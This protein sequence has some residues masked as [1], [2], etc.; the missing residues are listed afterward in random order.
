MKSNRDQV[1]QIKT[2]KNYLHCLNL[3]F[4]WVK[5]SNQ[6]N[7]FKAWS[8]MK[9]TTII[10]GGGLEIKIQEKYEIKECSR[11]PRTTYK[12][13]IYCGTIPSKSK[14]SLIQIRFSYNSYSTEFLSLEFLIYGQHKMI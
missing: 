4:L 13:Q 5:I 2:L 8:T 11:H 3:T 12:T 14:T 10:T 7:A 9:Y 1:K 6:G